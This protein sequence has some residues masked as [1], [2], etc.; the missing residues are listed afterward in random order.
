MKYM[1]DYKN[2]DFPERDFLFE[3]LSTMYP[4]ETYEMIKNAYKER[5]MHYEEGDSEMVEITQ[6]IYDHIKDVLAYKSKFILLLWTSYFWKS[7]AIAENQIKSQKGKQNQ[8]YLCSRLIKIREAFRLE[9]E[10][11]ACIEG[12]RNGR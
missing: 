7:D 1:P 5:H 11:P 4:H 2:S 12:L 10:N 6:K 8:S 3:I 9:Q